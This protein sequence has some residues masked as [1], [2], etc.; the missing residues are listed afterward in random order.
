MSSNTTIFINNQK[1]APLSNHTL[2]SNQ[3]WGPSLKGS[4]PS[5]T[6]SPKYKS[7]VLAGNKTSFDMFLSLGV[8]DDD[9]CCDF[10]FVEKVEDF[11][12]SNY[13][14]RVR[15]LDDF[16]INPNFQEILK[17]LSKKLSFS[18]P[19]SPPITGS[20][21]GVGNIGIGTVNTSSK[22]SV[23]ASP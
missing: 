23:T 14:S 22:L 20:Y 19:F 3:I 4:L 1:L 5:Y 16:F 15:L 12:T 2:L 8:D 13:G 10:V 21:S 9:K 17:F 6:V 7:Y 11:D 18:P